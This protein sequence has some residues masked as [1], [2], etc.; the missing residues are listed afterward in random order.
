VQHIPVQL[1][2]GLIQGQQELAPLQ[3]VLIWQHVAKGL[4]EPLQISK[5]WLSTVSLQCSLT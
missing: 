4:G 3:H 1:P 2:G 5:W